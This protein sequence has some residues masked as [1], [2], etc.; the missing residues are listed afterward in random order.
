[1]RLGD[2]VVITLMKFQDFAVTTAV[3]PEVGNNFIY[4]V[5]GLLGEWGEWLRSDDNAELG[6]CLWYIAM[7]STEAGLD[8]SIVVANALNRRLENFDETAMFELAQMAKRQM[9]DGGALNTEKVSA[10]LSLVI[11]LLV[12]VLLGEF[13]TYTDTPDKL[14][15]HLLQAVEKKLSDRATRGVLR[16]EGDY[17]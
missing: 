17:R 5:L 1:M 12:K 3:Y 4:P 7:I 2:Q 14:I 13:R 11:C 10:H 8:F 15:L 6:D 16:G 9:R